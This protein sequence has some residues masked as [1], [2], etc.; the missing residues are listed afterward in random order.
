MS[1]VDGF[2]A[3]LLGVYALDRALKLVL[4]ARFFRRPLPPP[5]TVWPI[6]S[7]IQ[8][9]TR[10]A[11]NLREHLEDRARLRYQGVVQH[12]LVCDASDACGQAVCQ[13][14][15]PQGERI[16]VPPDR[17]GGQVAAKTAKMR[18]GMGRAR[19]SVI[20]FVDD[21][22]GLPPGALETL[23]CHLA[24][25]G[26]GVVFGLACQTSWRTVGSSLISG[27]VNANALVGYVP[28]TFFCDPYTVTGHCFALEAAVLE[29][30]GGLAGL[31]NRIDDDHEIAR[32]VRRAGLS[33]RQS[34]LVYRVNNDL[35]TL[36]DYWVQMRRW[37]VIP[38]QTMMPFLTRREKTISALLTAGN[39]LPSFLALL[40]LAS[41]ARFSVLVALAGALALFAA[42]YAWCE[43][44]FLP[45]RT[46]LARWP[47][48]AVVV[49]VTPLHAAL[50][51]VL[52]GNT[53]KW[54][55]RVLR[56]HGGGHMEER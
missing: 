9:V 17:S 53:I 18:A 54:R 39:L 7:L 27:F 41:A 42:G 19:G 2:A 49:L 51:L 55:G 14:A 12:V 16:V 5:P 36:R 1:A 6:V 21:D 47:L 28:L 45:A 40:A 29:A 34:G 38:R 23:V 46:P 44:R 56:V 25:P 52:P 26:V 13:A 24:A 20:C 31:E 35:E 4:V 43:A 11:T 22:I 30:V 48:L 32:R 33:C 3:A 15:L 10:G 8:P 50:A 37:F